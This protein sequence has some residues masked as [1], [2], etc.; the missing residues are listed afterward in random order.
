MDREEAI[1]EAIREALLEAYGQGSRQH[2]LDIDPYSLYETIRVLVDD[3]AMS[4]IA[5]A[6][7]N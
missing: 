7:R 5:E 1:I 2:G 6:E 4:A 3:D